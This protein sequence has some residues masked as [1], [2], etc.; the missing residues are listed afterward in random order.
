MRNTAGGSDGEVVVSAEIKTAGYKSDSPIIRDISFSLSRGE[1]LL[2][3][4]PSGSGKTTLIFA[5]T[6]VLS[7]LL[8]GE[9]KGNI[10]ISDIN[11][12]D[13]NDF[14][15]IPSK[16]GV[17]LQ[18]PDKQLAM[19]TPFDEVV[20]VLEN[21]G[22]SEEEAYSKA[23]S[24][25][26]WVGLKDKAFRDVETLSG[27]EKKRLCIAASIVH[28]PELMIFDEPTANLDPLG[29]RMIIEYIEKIRQKGIAVIVAEHKAGY[30]IDRSR[31]IIVIRRGRVIKRIKPPVSMRD[32]EILESF[33][34]DTGLIR[35]KALQKSL[36]N[37]AVIEIENLYFKYEGSPNY[38]LKNVS[39]KIRKGEVFALVGH[40]GAGKTTLLKLIA[41][42]YKP[43]SGKILVH[44]EHPWRLLKSRGKPRVFYVPQHPDYLFVKPTIRDEFRLIAK[45]LKKDFGKLIEE[46]EYFAKMLDHSPY[47]LSHGQRRWL[48]WSITKSYDPDI[49]LLDEPTAGL[50]LV[51]Y[52]ELVEWILRLVR[53][54]KTIVISTHDIRLVSELATDAVI[55]RSGEIVGKGVKDAVKYLESSIIL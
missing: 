2:L 7:N 19:P 34:V 1:L 37:E 15:K 3:T 39:L 16:I 32:R 44:N 51:L 31:E 42:F 25:L 5:I 47:R 14:T 43:S 55:L 49:F 12:L 53:K 50:D 20:F 10:R 36:D 35:R 9:V 28:E 38:A 24:I 6:G 48:A 18:D 41:G 21:L 23:M 45:T 54:G 11:P 40:N 27:G 4:G 46:N 52:R 33:G 22:M 17:V 8:G 26:E 30:F 13:P 29:V